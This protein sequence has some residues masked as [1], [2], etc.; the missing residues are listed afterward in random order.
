[1]KTLLLS[2]LSASAL[3]VDL[4]P[5]AQLTFRHQ[6]IDFRFTGVEPSKLVK[7]ILT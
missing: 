4:K 6:G 5:N 3:A 2:L 1:M 7:R